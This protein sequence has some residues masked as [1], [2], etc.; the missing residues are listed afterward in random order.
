M[1]WWR[2][3]AAVAALAFLAWVGYEI[4]RAGGDVEVGRVAAPDTM[5]HGKVTGK[6]IDGR[7]WSLDYDTVTMSPDGSQATIA[8]VRD[9]R[10]HR[11][12]KPD[13]LIKADGVTVN[14]ITNDLTVAGP[15]EVSETI[16][17]GRQRTFKTTG[18][19][20]VGATRV[21]QLDHQAT[22]TEAGTTIVVASATVDFRT[23]DVTLGRIEGTKPGAGS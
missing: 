6:R 23:G 11:A 16:G 2:I 5:S 8:H 22:I 19:R 14:T 1:T 17:S 3:A 15:V 4:G 12:G 18:A 10:L 13:V 7:A 9:G 20:Y 21:L